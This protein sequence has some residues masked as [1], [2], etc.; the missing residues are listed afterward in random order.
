MGGIGSGRFWRY[1][2]KDKVEDKRS[3][4]VRC[5]QRDGLLYAGNSFKWQWSREGNPV[6]N[7]KVKGR[8]L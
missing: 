3:I 4:D 8:V 5:W 7:I 2:A 1:D 6:G